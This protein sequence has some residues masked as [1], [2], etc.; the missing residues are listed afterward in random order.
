MQQMA[1]IKNYYLEAHEFM[2]GFR[3]PG[4]NFDAVLESNNQEFYSFV[5]NN[6]EVD[7]TH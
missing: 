1:K 6:L 3:R 2:V 4:I 7:C 5:S